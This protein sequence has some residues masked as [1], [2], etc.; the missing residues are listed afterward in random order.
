MGTRGLC[1][2]LW[3]L[4]N[5]PRKER[6]VH[7]TCITFAPAGAP[8]QY[9]QRACPRPLWCQRYAYFLLL[10][11]EYIVDHDAHILF[12]GNA[13]AKTGQA[14]VSCCSK[15]SR[16]WSQ[17]AVC[18]QLFA[19]RG[20][21]CELRNAAGVR[22]PWFCLMHE[23]NLNLHFFVWCFFSFSCFTTFSHIVRYALHLCF[24]FCPCPVKW[25][26]PPCWV[27]LWGKITTREYTA[28]TNLMT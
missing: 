18:R 15:T 24:L 8:L 9:R 7:H 6:A 20:M 14:K 11:T 10:N 21:Y 23:Q 25:H 28:C 22:G 17:A 12:A 4:V 1:S 5:Q 13:I 3:Q 19:Y 2:H 27:G 26:T 16:L